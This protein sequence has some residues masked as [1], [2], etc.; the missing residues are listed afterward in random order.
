MR[1][2]H[3]TLGLS[4]LVL[5]GVA[6]P[7][8]LVAQRRAP[9][10]AIRGR[11]AD[12]RLGSDD[13]TGEL[14]AFGGDT[15]WIA[16][17]AGLRGVPFD[18]VRDVRIHRHG[19]DGGAVLRWGLI[20]AGVTALGMSVACSQVEGTDCAGVA[21]SVLVSWGVVGGILGWALASTSR[22]PV[23]ATPDGLRPWVRYPAGLPPSRRPGDRSGSGASRPDRR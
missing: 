9:V 1:T 15:L 17:D 20:G 4:L 21:G 5:S 10:E 23:P 11:T 2:V 12:V 3:I 19:M 22:Q 16:G 8:P 14:L 6:F 18:D 7:E 13:L